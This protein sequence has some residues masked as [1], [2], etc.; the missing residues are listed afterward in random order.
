MNIEWHIFMAHCVDCLVKLNRPAI[1]THS[2]N[3]SMSNFRSLLSV[4]IC[5]RELRFHCIY[6]QI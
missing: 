5:Y 6:N 1:Y 2:L 3:D 4:Q